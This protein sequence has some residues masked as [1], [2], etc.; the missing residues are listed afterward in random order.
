MSQL[1]DV[2]LHRREAGAT[3]KGCLSFELCW[4]QV[5]GMVELFK[6]KVESSW[7]LQP[8]CCDGIGLV[9]FF[10]LLTVDRK[11]S[12]PVS[13]VEPNCFLQGTQEY[14]CKGLC[15]VVRCLENPFP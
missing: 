12:F 7:I 9:C 8:G 13:V 15:I 5:K 14:L 6:L 1:D 2:N 4:D 10:F 11:A 3:R